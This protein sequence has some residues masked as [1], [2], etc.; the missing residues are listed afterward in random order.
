M[1]DF[2]AIMFT[3]D[4]IALALGWSPLLPVA[5]DAAVD[6]ADSPVKAFCIERTVE[7]VTNNVSFTMQNPLPWKNTRSVNTQLTQFHD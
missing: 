5:E 6:A 2:W 3:M 4:M 7:L 1:P